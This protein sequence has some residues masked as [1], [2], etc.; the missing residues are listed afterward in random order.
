MVSETRWGR[1]SRWGSSTP[2]ERLRDEPSEAEKSFVYAPR[3]ALQRVQEHVHLIH[4][5]DARPATIDGHRRC[6]EDL[7]YGNS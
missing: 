4:D 1:E 2:R 3:H 5:D 7:N 6:D